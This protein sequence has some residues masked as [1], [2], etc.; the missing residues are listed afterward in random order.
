M[1]V[2]ECSNNAPILNFTF[3]LQ[4]SSELA[5]VHMMT[6]DEMQCMF[7]KLEVK[8]RMYK[9]EPLELE[10]WLRSYAHLK[11]NVHLAMF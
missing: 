2:V 6:I 1:E 9:K 10:F 4:K 7:W 5:H 3:S 11:F 8:R